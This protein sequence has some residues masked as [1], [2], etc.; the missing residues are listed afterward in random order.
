MFRSHSKHLAISFVTTIAL[1]AASCGSHH[2]IT[3]PQ[4]PLA[5]EVAAASSNSAGGWESFYPLASGNRWN[6]DTVYRVEVRPPTGDPY[7]SEVRGTREIEQTCTEVR[8]ENPYLIERVTVTD[9]LNTSNYWIRYRQDRSGL[10]SSTTRA[11]PPVNPR[12]RSIARPSLQ[13]TA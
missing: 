7:R 13:R 4:M 8:G 1:G 9:E 10:S 3:S 12:R 2:D 11:I 6:Y 5:N